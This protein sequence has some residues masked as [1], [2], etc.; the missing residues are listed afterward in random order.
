MSAPASV[1][2]LRRE[3]E[4]EQDAHAATMAQLQEQTRT[5]QA[6]LAEQQEAFTDL[7]TR[8]TELRVAKSEYMAA[9]VAGRTQHMTF[10]T[11]SALLDGF[12]Y[13]LH[14]KLEGPEMSVATSVLQKLE[15]AALEALTPYGPGRLS[16]LLTSS[17]SAV[18]TT[19]LLVLFP[20]D[21]RGVRQWARKHLSSCA[22]C[23]ARQAQ[24]P[25]WTPYRYD[26][27]GTGFAAAP[28]LRAIPNKHYHHVAISLLQER[29][30]ADR[31][32]TENQL[33]IMR[34][35]ALVRVQSAQTGQR[36][37]DSAT[38]CS[39]M[40]SSLQAFLAETMTELRNTISVSA[41][42]S[43][44]AN[45]NSELSA[46]IEILLH[47]VEPGVQVR[48][49]QQVAV[50]STG[51]SCTLVE[52][53]T[54]VSVPLHVSALA[55]LLRLMDDPAQRGYVIQHVLT[56]LAR[57]IGDALG[58]G[59]LAAHY[60]ATGLRFV[61]ALYRLAVH[62]GLVETDGKSK[63][64]EQLYLILQALAVFGT[65]V[66]AEV[67]TPHV[68]AS[69]PESKPDAKRAA[70]RLARALL[71]Q[72]AAPKTLVV[73]RGDDADAVNMTIK[74]SRAPTTFLEVLNRAFS[75]NHRVPPTSRSTALD[76]FM[77]PKSKISLGLK[78]F[79]ELVVEV[80]RPYHPCTGYVLAAENGVGGRR[81]APPCVPVIDLPVDVVEANV[82][83][84]EYVE[85]LLQQL[86]EI[87]ASDA[88]AA[89]GRLER[90]GK[91]FVQQVVSTLQQTAPAERLRSQWT[92]AQITISEVS[93][94][95]VDV[96][97]PFAMTEVD[98]RAATKPLLYLHVVY[99]S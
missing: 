74:V 71:R 82:R 89:E 34:T 72:F 19:G 63:T 28:N 27:K 83:V 2:A 8:V 7:I 24:L 86:N 81:R 25:A 57:R 55:P 23:A 79:R 10:N 31:M 15:N 4:A 85:Q 3:L 53:E 91:A 92:A 95:C 76:A 30:I 44:G 99:N 94:V 51:A 75:S 84:A 38:A 87:E 73:P 60:T 69:P 35:T 5:F 16:A 6:V 32:D 18:R 29:S 59:D 70:L 46:A 50:T 93:K 68:P 22:S 67:I 97:V 1:E 36:L 80:H 47:M 65:S 66:E 49:M 77:S 14:A 12:L 43:T 45:P 41:P 61:E 56:P 48:P 37:A 98:A 54:T 42:W 88:V 64:L 39:Q 20:N 62:Q 9:Q 13:S 58:D 78:L 21:V 96:L 33:V 90:E 40:T 52:V 11:G 17:A 26:S